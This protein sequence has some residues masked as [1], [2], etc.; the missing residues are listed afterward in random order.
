MLVLPT[1]QVLIN[2]GGVQLYVYTPDLPP[3]AAAMP[4]ITGIAENADGSFLLT[5]TGLNGISEGAGYG[6]DAEMASNYPIVRLTDP[7]GHV[8]YARTLRLEQHRRRDR[9]R[10]RRPPTS[11]CPSGC[12]RTPTRCRWSPT[13]PP[14]PRSP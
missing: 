7:S 5:G 4:T 8:Y 3:V 6:D 11:P 9:A 14:R 1:G 12:R 10:P 13:G 2:N